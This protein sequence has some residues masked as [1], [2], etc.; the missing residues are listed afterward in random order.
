MSLL[1]LRGSY[2]AQSFST[3]LEEGFPGFDKWTILWDFDIFIDSM[4]RSFLNA[5]KVGI[6]QMFS[7]KKFEI[8]KKI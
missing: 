3:V 2:A 4:F 6:F 7:L 1:G 5:L 8:T